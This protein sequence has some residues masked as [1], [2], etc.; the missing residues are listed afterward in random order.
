MD[1]GE[2]TVAR[3]ETEA[4]GVSGT[5]LPCVESELGF[6]VLHAVVVQQSSAVDTSPARCILAALV[7]EHFL[8]LS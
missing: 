6:F 2:A 7:V 5:A 8:R 3:V 1:G 4:S